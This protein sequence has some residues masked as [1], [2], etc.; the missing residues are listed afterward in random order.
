MSTIESEKIM[1][2]DI[3][4]FEA[5]KLLETE[6]F[7]QAISRCSEAIA[8]FGLNRNCLLIKAR[9]HIHLE[10]YGFAEDA[11]NSVL[12]LDPE[13]PAAWAML[14]EVYF[15]QGKST[16][17]EYCKARLESI[18]PALAESLEFGEDDQ[19]EDESRDIPAEIETVVQA[20]DNSA[21][22]QV[23]QSVEAKGD[24]ETIVPLEDLHKDIGKQIAE[25]ENLPENDTEPAA[26]N[27]AVPDKPTNAVTKPMGIKLELFETVTFA[28]ICYKQGKFEKAL[29]IYKKLLNNNPGNARLKEKIRIIESKIGS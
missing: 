19:Q 4:A 5:M 10:E 28:D 6:E 1:T 9:A 22:Q 2:P 14:G 8:T 7:R 15:R 24:D 3:V 12:Q 26:D 27:V 21:R 18:F 11:L 20:E 16:R 13:H 23:E 29:S 25:A 17:L